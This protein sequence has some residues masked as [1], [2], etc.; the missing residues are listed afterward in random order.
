[1]VKFSDL[2]LRNTI[3]YIEPNISL[4]QNQGFL[5]HQ[6]L[7]QKL[8]FQFA[9]FKKQSVKLPF[10]HVGII[11]ITTF[12]GSWISLELYRQQTNYYP[13]R[14]DFYKGTSLALFD[15]M[16]TKDDPN[17]KWSPLFQQ[18]VRITPE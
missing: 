2:K 5:I 11:A 6:N 12:F 15:Y 16:Y 4:K 7:S 10:A 13:S 3:Q 9:N 8:K 14:K 17:Y 1:M 18:S